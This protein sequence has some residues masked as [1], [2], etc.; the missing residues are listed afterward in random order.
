MDNFLVYA[1]LW[2]ALNSF[3]SVLLGYLLRMEPWCAF[4]FFEDMCLVE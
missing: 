4:F 1:F 2:N 3:V